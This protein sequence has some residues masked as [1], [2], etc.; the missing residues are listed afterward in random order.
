MRSFN[1]LR[2]NFYLTCVFKK[3]NQELSHFYVE[4]DNSKSL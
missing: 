3:T 1:H 4:Q 2:G